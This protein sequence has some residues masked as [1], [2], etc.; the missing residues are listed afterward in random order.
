[1]QL[2]WDRRYSRK[3][4]S[5]RDRSKGN[6]ELS[7]GGRTWA[8]FTCGRSR[9]SIKMEKG[10]FP[11]RDGER[12]HVKKW[13][14]DF[15]VLRVFNSL[16]NIMSCRLT[17]VAGSTPLATERSIRRKSLREKRAMG[18]R[19]VGVIGVE[20]GRCCG[21]GGNRTGK[22]LECLFFPRRVDGRSGARRSSLSAI[23]LMEELAR[24]GRG[25]SSESAR[26]KAPEG[27]PGGGR[28]GAGTIPEIAFKAF[29]RAKAE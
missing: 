9:R 16:I 27:S 17:P 14:R 8:R 18:S 19:G 2:L 25:R 7:S 5:P 12:A 11:W 29:A 22:K 15:P 28:R 3:I 4:Y 20:G 6:R 10:N 26:K 13:L 24:G 21:T 23:N 1:M